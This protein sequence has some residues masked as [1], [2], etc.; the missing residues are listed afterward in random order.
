M[1][2][3][4]FFYKLTGNQVQANQ[5]SDYWRSH[6]GIPLVH[7]GT[8]HHPTWAPSTSNPI[9]APLTVPDVAKHLATLL[10]GAPAADRLT[11]SEPPSVETLPKPNEINTSNTNNMPENRLLQLAVYL[12]ELSTTSWSTKSDRPHL[13]RISARLRISS[14]KAP[15]DG[16]CV[17]VEHLNRCKTSLQYQICRGTWHTIR[18]HVQR[19]YLIVWDTEPDQLCVP[20]LFDFLVHGDRLS[21]EPDKTL[22]SLFMHFSPFQNAELGMHYFNRGLISPFLFTSWISRG[23]RRRGLFII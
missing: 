1:Q 6:Y 13:I 10:F 22:R 9:L 2:G 7:D 8:P 4:G 11:A 23:V 3:Q 20:A 16:V 15:L 5:M 14:G 17:C 21:P 19:S 12:R 18:D